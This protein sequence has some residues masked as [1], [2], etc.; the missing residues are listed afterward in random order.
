MYWLHLWLT[1]V[2]ITAPK[3]TCNQVQ[4]IHYKNLTLEILCFLFQEIGRNSTPV[5]WDGNVAQTYVL[6]KP[7]RALCIHKHRRKVFSG[8]DAISE[9]G[10]ATSDLSTATSAPLEYSYTN[11]HWI[12]SRKAKFGKNVLG[13]LYCKGHF[14]RLWKIPNKLILSKHLKGRFGAVCP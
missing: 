6:V 3:I 2:S 5:P 10:H 12:E 7:C 14:S 11:G 8:W 13:S 9:V 1:L 4:P